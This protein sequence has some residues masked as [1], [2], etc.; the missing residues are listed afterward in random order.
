MKGDLGGYFDKFLWEIFIYYRGFRGEKTPEGILF[1]DK[2]YPTP[3]LFQKAVDTFIREGAGII[4]N[5][6]NHKNK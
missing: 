5:S 1:K 2:L 6:L 4:G 3:E